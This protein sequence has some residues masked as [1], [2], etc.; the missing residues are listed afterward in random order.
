MK[1][2]S[3]IDL[4]NQLLSVISQMQSVSHLFVE[5]G[6]DFSRKRKNFFL[7]YHSERMVRFLGFFS[8]YGFGSRLLPATSEI[9]A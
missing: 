8:G 3:P 5:T 7:K 2:N 6:K 9:V 1:N 4:K